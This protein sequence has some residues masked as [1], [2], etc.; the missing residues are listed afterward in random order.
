[1]VAKL[2]EIRTAEICWLW[3]SVQ[4]ASS[5]LLELVPEIVSLTLGTRLSYRTLA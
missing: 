4:T 2:S 1:M 5:N 3:F